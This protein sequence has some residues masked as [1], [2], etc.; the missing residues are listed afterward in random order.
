MEKEIYEYMIQKLEELRSY[1]I[2]YSEE[3]LNTVYNN[4]I[5]SEKTFEEIKNK[6]NELYKN[7]LEEAKLNALDKKAEAGEYSNFD[8]IKNTLNLILNS[9]LGQYL[10]VYGG[11]VPYLIT[12]DIPKR[13]IGDIDFHAS[14]DDMEKIRDIIENNPK[15]YKVLFDSLSVSR[16]EFGI[17]LKVN[18][19]A[20]S[21][22]PVIYTQEG[23]VI[24]NFN[25]Q[26]STDEM[27]VKS[28]LFHGLTEKNST[29]LYEY[30]GR[31]IKVETPEIIYIQKSTSLRRKDIKDL[32]VLDKIIDIKKVEYYKNLTKIP[33]VLE[34]KL[35]DF[36]KK[37]N[38][39]NNIK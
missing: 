35:L 36:S 9:E 19:V 6:I 8:Q 32:R 28:T 31:Q 13:V 5:N 20:V 12:G 33:T 14:I 17:E 25:V 3:K 37:I 23:K 22:F 34:R 24:N 39:Q 21:I 30:N 27:E 38:E 15:R 4:F 7:S 18:N 26:Q 11:I 2:D 16:S 10:E 29:I 1:G